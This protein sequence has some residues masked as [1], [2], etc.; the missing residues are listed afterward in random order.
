MVAPVQMNE[1]ARA[2]LRDLGSFGRSLV[3]RNAS[4]W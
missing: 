1:I 3:T 2:L 4:F